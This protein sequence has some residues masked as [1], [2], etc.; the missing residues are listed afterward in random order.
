MTWRKQKA[1]HPNIGIYRHLVLRTRR[2]VIGIEGHVFLKSH[3]NLLQNGPR[4]NLI[5][6]PVFYL[7]NGLALRLYTTDMFWVRPNETKRSVHWHG[8]KAVR[9]P[10]G[11]S[12][13]YSL[14]DMGFYSWFLYSKAFVFSSKMLNL[15]FQTGPPCFRSM[16][17]L[18][19]SSSRSRW[20]IF[21]YKKTKIWKRNS[22]T[23]LQNTWITI[24]G[25][26]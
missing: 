11:P 19:L 5:L 14:S 15:Q 6:K 12:G 2:C 24:G 25:E 1:I 26:K 16:F 20:M 18:N 9:G 23:T 10:Q 3:W 13:A 17:I 21:L 4:Q 8:S 7:V 22:K